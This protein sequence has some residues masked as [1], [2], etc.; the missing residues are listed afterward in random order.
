MRKKRTE[1]YV[2]INDVAEKANVSIATVSRVL[3]GGRV[4]EERKMR[5]LK[6]ISD[7]KYQ[8]NN[9]ARN[10]ASVNSTKRVAIV[11]PALHTAYL[12]IIKGFKEGLS[13]YKYEPVI[14]EYNNSE[15][16]FI[17]ICDRQERS[18]EVKGIVQFSK[19]H[20]LEYK[21]IFNV[22]TDE[23]TF[24]LSDEFLNS[25][26]YIYM[27]G[28]KVLEEFL[29]KNVFSEIDAEVADLES[30]NDNNIVVT[31]TVDEALKLISVGFK[32][33]IKVIERAVNAEKLYQNLSNLRID[34]YALG[35]ILSQLIIKKINKTEITEVKL[36]VA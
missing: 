27:P 31:S 26:V 8:P 25:K 7:L 11:I 24:E 34:F 22:L 9:S 32:G 18:S 10:L 3:N 21:E 12:P 13:L 6:A 23:I 1:A 30:L 16:E 28:N 4:R 2:T 19:S 35:I 33:E 20:P 29:I 36:T 5:V 14:E 15:E 17:K